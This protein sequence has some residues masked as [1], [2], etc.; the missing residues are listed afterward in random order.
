[1]SHLFQIDEKFGGFSN[2]WI[3]STSCN[4]QYAFKHKALPL[5]FIL[6]QLR[7]GLF[8]WYIR[9]SI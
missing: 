1:M 9:W 6:S 8:R 3:F 5:S 4:K 2:L 7:Y